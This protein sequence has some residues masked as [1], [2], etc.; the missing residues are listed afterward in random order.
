MHAQNETAQ[1][2]KGPQTEPFF[3]VQD[4]M[5]DAMQ[6]DEMA[7]RRAAHVLEERLLQRDRD[8]QETRRQVFMEQVQGVFSYTAVAEGWNINEADVDEV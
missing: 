5:D 2:V 7:I 6:E 3:V 4:M 1:G 8:E